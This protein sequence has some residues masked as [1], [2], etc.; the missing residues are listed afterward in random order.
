VGL[1]IDYLGG[2]GEISD[3]YVGVT[4]ALSPVTTV[5]AGAFF[6]NDRSVAATT[7]DGVFVY[8]TTGFN[9]GKLF[10]KTTQ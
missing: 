5:S 2:V 4:L 9:V 10:S 8:L 3:T 7:Y 1:A 6:D